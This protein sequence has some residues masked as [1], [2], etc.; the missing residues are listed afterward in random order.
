MG[1]DKQ[2]GLRLTRRFSAFF[3]WI[4]LVFLAERR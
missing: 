4:P 1:A 3:R 2:A